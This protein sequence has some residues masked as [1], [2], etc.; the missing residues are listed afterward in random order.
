MVSDLCSKCWPLNH[1]STT[2]EIIKSDLAR[3]L[4]SRHNIKAP[5]YSSA[6]LFTFPET[7]RGGGEEEPFGGNS[8]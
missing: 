2:Y 4:T 8:R 5:D 1:L 6:T 7:P 3:R